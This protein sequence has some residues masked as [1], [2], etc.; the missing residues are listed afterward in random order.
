MKQFYTVPIQMEANSKQ[1]AE[2]KVNKLVEM[3][4]RFM[5]IW[6]LVCIFGVAYLQD[7]QDNMERAKALRAAD[8]KFKTQRTQKRTVSKGELR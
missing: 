5:P 2:Q 4:G 3:A 6:D 8:P 7:R 1:E